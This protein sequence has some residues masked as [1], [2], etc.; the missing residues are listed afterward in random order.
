MEIIW[1]NMEKI[2]KKYGQIARTKLEK[3][4]YKNS[5]MTY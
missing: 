5:M 2:G 3:G 4:D 1:K